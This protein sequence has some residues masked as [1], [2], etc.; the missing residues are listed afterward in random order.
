MTP[1][2]SNGPLLDTARHIVAACDVALVA[3]HEEAVSSLAADNADGLRGGLLSLVEKIETALRLAKAAEVVTAQAQRAAT[4][5]GDNAGAPDL[6][7]H[8]RG[9]RCAPCTDRRAHRVRG[10]TPPSACHECG[11]HG[12]AGCGG[13]GENLPPKG[14][15]R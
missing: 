3:A 13:T 10:T 6:F 4:A 14:G 11:G 12:C 7:P 8:V 5:A 2:T 15:A 9:C 1:A